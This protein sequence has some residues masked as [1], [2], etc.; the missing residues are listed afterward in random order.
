M[1][2]GHPFYLDYVPKSIYPFVNQRT[3]LASQDFDTVMPDYRARLAPRAIAW[4]DRDKQGPFAAAGYQGLIGN[5]STT[6]DP[7]LQ[8]KGFL[9]WSNRNL[10]LIPAQ[11]IRY[12]VYQQLAQQPRTSGRQTSGEAPNQGIYSGYTDVQDILRSEIYQ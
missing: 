6:D 3:D 2:S 11:P 10:Y 5:T 8:A 7:F 4:G 1:A 12:D 9:G